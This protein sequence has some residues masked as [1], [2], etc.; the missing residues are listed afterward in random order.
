M[1]VA[2]RADG[3]GEIDV[4]HDWLVEVVSVVFQAAAVVASEWHVLAELA[5]LHLCSCTCCCMP[6]MRPGV[7][8]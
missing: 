3:V 2:V 6:G 1:I 8:Q 4:G 5:C 7:S